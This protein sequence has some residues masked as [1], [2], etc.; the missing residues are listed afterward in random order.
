MKQIKK[1]I[2]GQQ[3]IFDYRKAIYWEDTSSLILSD[4]HVGKLNHFQKNG[5]AIP[6][7]GS[8]NNLINIKSLVNEYDP[9]QVYIL[10]D[11]F[12]SSYNKEWDDWLVYF[13]KS[14]IKFALILGNH[15]KNDSK[16]LWNSNITVVDQLTKGPF[17]FTHYPEQE[18]DQFNICGHVH[19]AVKLRGL[20][21][22]YMKLN[23]F[24]ISDNQLILP[25][26]GTF[27]G[28]HILKPN[29]T[30]HVICLSTDGL[31]EL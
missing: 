17:L 11:L 22:Q 25:A 12:H 23:C 14:K 21:R 1:K 18:I 29:K 13:S 26:F 9:D 28:S 8:R 16:K 5:I 15:D 6:S 31:F 3:F 24:Y 4:V 20:G 2:K 19:P 30:D 10:G 27:T 7:D